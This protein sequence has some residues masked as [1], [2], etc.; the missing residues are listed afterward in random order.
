MSAASPEEMIPCAPS[1]AAWARLASKSSRQSRLSVPSELFISRMISAG[2]P[3]KRPPHIG[4]EIDLRLILLLPALLTPLLASAGCDRQKH[5]GQQVEQRDVSES[6]ADAGPVE[7]VDRSHKGKPAPDPT[8]HDLDGGDISL[9]DFEGVPVLVNLWASWCA[10]C[11]KELPTL[12]TLE[13]AQARDGQLGVIAVS[14]D[15]GPKP[16]VDAFLESKKI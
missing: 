16:S 4:L 9:A 5:E 6:T 7:G 11:V 10:P 15:M 14:Q 1:I 12:E 2:P 13:Q 3:A 8:F